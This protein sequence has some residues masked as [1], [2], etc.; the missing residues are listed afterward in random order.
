MT[1]SNICSTYRSG[2][3]GEDCPDY[4]NP[5]TRVIEELRELETK[6]KSLRAFLENPKARDLVSGKMYALLAKQ[7]TVMAEYAEILRER[8]EI[9]DLQD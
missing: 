9:W 3:I 7:A 6:L 2:G 1:K 4:S 8:L 5:K